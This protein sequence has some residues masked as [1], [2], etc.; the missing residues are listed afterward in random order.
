MKIFN[1]DNCNQLIY[2]ENTYCNN[3]GYNLGYCSDTGKL[4]SFKIDANDVW[5]SIGPTTFGRLYRP[6]KMYINQCEVV[7]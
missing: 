7:I 2:F 4:C 6:C 3:C 5:T 1:C